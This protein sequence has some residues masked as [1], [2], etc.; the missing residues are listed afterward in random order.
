MVGKRDLVKRA[1]WLLILLMPLLWGF[2][3]VYLS[4]HKIEFVS[5]LSFA[6]WAGVLIILIVLVAL[7]EKRCLANA[8]HREEASNV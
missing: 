1:A 3:I 8:T 4:A 5:R 6:L 2:I 7:I